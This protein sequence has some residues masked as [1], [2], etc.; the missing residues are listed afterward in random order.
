MLLLVP[1]MVGLS[2]AGASHLPLL[3]TKPVSLPGGLSTT[4]LHFVTGLF[5]LGI[6][7]WPLVHW[8]VMTMQV[9]WPTSMDAALSLDAAGE[10]AALSMET[11][12]STRQSGGSSLLRIGLGGMG[13]MI[14]LG[15][16]ALVLVGLRSGRLRILYPVL[17]FPVLMASGK[18][19]R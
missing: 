8:N 2:V 13:P 4:L 15:G 19:P 3:F 10:G 6:C 7:L 14:L 11:V 18:S 12:G 5:I 9:P 17:L 1:I 16:I